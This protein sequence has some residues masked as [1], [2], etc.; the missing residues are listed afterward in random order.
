M[1]FPFRVLETGYGRAALN[2]GLDEAILESVATGTQ[3]PTLRLYGWNPATI[4]L[5]YFQKIEDEID[6]ESCR[7]AGVDIVRRITGG[8]AV[9][10][11]AEVTYSI[12]IPEGHPLAPPSIAESY[13]ILCAGIIEGLKP[14]GLEAAFAP[15]NDILVAGKKISGNAQTRKRG[16]LLQHGTVLLA[17]DP[18]MMF[19]LLRVPKEKTLGK[20]I[21]D[22]KARV[23]SL[24]DALG[25]S[26]GFPE[27][28]AN[29][30]NG[31]VRALG[32]DMERA[33]PSELELATAARLAD[34]KFSLSSW[35]E[36]R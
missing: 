15:I 24:E 7:K 16:C 27:A 34:E 6:V 13:G 14:F 20:L 28:E 11:E 1:G 36:R 21:A 30:L 35:T 22:V 10:H 2:M 12:A 31:F 9:F 3:L 17:V 29:L 19:S 25:R 33:S 32:L 18:E 23:T 4:S 5:G 8:G 26:V